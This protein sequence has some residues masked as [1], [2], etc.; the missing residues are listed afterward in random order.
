MERASVLRAEVASMGR[1]YRG[2][3]YPPELRERLAR[4]ARERVGAG[5]SWHR[6]ARDLGV[7][8]VTL[9]RWC[10]EGEVAAFL[11]VHVEPAPTKRAGFVLVSPDGWRVEGFSFEQV[12]AFLRSLG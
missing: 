5:E 4:H 6:V 11:P 7:K 12:V 1:R 9:A 8:A 10:E 3:P 2:Q